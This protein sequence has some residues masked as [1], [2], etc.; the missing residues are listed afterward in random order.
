MIER[1][2]LVIEHLERSW[3]PLFRIVRGIDGKALPAI[4]VPSPYGFPVEA[5]PRSSHIGELRWYLEEF[6]DYPFSPHTIHAEHV[7]DALKSWGTAAF[8]ALFDRRDAAEWL[9]NSDSLHIRADDAVIL[10]WP[11]EALYDAQ[12]GAFLAHH[13]RV[14]RRLNQLPD[15]PTLGKLA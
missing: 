2:E 14:E 5:Y 4:A 9:A 13:K 3:P 8:V 11:W 1:R 7:L 6:L 15:P 10:S 12:F